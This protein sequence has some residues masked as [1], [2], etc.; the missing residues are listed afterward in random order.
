MGEVEGEVRTNY[1][2]K[3][4][5]KILLGRLLQKMI[6]KGYSQV[7]GYNK[8]TYFDHSYNRITVGRENGE[9][10]DISF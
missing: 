4:D 6:D 2:M 5:S 9:N 3:T 7:E 1:D 10:T 8:F